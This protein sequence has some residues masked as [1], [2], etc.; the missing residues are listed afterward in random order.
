MVFERKGEN[1][2]PEQSMIRKNGSVALKAAI[3]GKCAGNMPSA[4]G[5]VPYKVILEPLHVSGIGART[6]RFLRGLRDPSIMRLF[7][8][9][10][11]EYEGYWPVRIPAGKLF[12]CHRRNV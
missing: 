3:G 5:S 10:R 12:K 2:D 6:T 7:H 4:S 1:I 9:L 11:G 8:E